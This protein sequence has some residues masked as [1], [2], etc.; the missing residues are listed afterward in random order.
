MITI[1]ELQNLNN[2][3]P[4]VTSQEVIQQRE[5]LLTMMNDANNKIEAY[6]D[7]NQAGINRIK[8]LLNKR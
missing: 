4:D 7:A 5:E 2:G 6:I 8:E 1:E 3:M